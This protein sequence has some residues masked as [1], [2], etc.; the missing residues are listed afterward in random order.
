MLEQSKVK[1]GY[2]AVDNDLGSQITDSKFAVYT[3]E[4]NLKFRLIEERQ[5]IYNRELLL[6]RLLDAISCR[7]DQYLE[8]IESNVKTQ[9]LSDM[10]AS[11]QMRRQLIWLRN[12]KNIS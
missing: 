9:E 2:G 1:G 12:S 7:A 11:P 10:E 5:V 4:I 6:E 8:P 3:C